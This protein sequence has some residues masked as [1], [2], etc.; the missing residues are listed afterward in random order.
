MFSIASGT[1]QKV[2]KSLSHTVQQ[3]TLVVLR[4][5]LLYDSYKPIPP[6]GNRGYSNQGVWQT[7]PKIG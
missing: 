6:P 1:K 5:K 3:S 7:F 2:T 4:Q